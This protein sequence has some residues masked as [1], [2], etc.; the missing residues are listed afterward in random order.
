MKMPEKSP[1]L[2]A[3]VLAYIQQNY[4]AITGFVMAFFMAILRAWFLQQKSSYRQRLLD[5]SICGALTLSC[6]SM[7]TYLGVGEHVSTFVGGL[8]GFVGAEKIRE[9]LFA[10]IRKKIE[11]NDISL[12]GK[13]DDSYNDSDEFRR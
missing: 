5:G 11:V 6:M 7:L 3:A 10:L 1:D 8:F 4:N 9:F 12:G 13:S 2:W